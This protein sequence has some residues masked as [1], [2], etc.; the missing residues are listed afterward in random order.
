MS[1]E[2]KMRQFQKEWKQGK[3]R[4]KAV[5]VGA[6]VAVICVA[7]LGTYFWKGE[8]AE[9]EIDSLRQIRQEAAAV[10]EKEDGEILSIAS[11][12][13]K[14]EY[15]ELFLQNPDLIGWLTIEGTKIDYPVMWTPED[16]DYYSN[17]GFDKEESQNGLL[18]LDAASNI[19]EYGGNLIV[20]GHNMK[21]GSMFADLLNYEKEMFWEEHKEI[22][23]DTLY[24]SRVY[25]ITTVAK[26]SD[27][28][29]LPFEFTNA[30]EVSAKSA[31]RKMEEKALYD[32]GAQMRYGDD[33]LTLATCDYS[34]DDGR[35]VVMA[36]RVR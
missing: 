13:V 12:E 10:D 4:G 22:L 2:K 35:L 20:Y 14:D 24:E 29:E 6:C 17:R 21:N 26:E 15:Q 25:E 31:I 30:D 3:H 7:A 32:T 28:D 34:E 33:F 8:E 18:F 9:K 36:K 27:V 11:R 1:L 5:A 16:P 19:N 23:F